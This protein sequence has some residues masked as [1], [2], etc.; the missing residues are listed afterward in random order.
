MPKKKKIPS[1]NELI[2]KI[3]AICPN[4]EFG[5][6]ND[7]QITIETGYAMDGTDEDEPLQPISEID[8]DAGLEDEDSEDEDEDEDSE[9]GDDDD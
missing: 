8:E 3:M 7:G 4:A 1:Y 5:E 2:D 6:D 9:D